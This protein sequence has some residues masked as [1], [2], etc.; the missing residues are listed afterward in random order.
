MRFL[1][2]TLCTLISISL[3]AQK[4]SPKK[5]VKVAEEFMA[6]GKFSDAGEAYGAAY[7]VKKDKEKWAYDAGYAHFRARNYSKA[8]KYFRPISK[9]NAQWPLAGFFYAKSLKA[10]GSFEKAAR[11]FRKF[12][13]NWQGDPNHDLLGMVE[14][15][16]LGCEQALTM[17]GA[18]MN[19]E[20]T[21]LDFN[22]ESEEFAPTPFSDDIIYFSTDSEG[23]VQIQRS[24]FTNGSWS[25]PIEAN[26]PQGPTGHTCQGVFNPDQTAFYFT[27][28][29]DDRPWESRDAVCEIYGTMKQNG[30][31]TSP[32]KLR[33]YIKMDGQTATQPCVAHADGMEYLYF[34]ADREGGQGGMDIWFCNREIG[35]ETFDFSFPENAGPVVNTA[36]DEFSPF[37]DSEEKT[38]YFSSNGHP[39]LGGF[40]IF[41]STGSG[42]KWMK[43][44][45]MPMP[46]NSSL[47]DYYYKKAPGSD[48]AFFASN[49]PTIAWERTTDDNVFQVGV[50]TNVLAQIS[51]DLFDQSSSK[52][53][54]N[55]TLM[56]HQVD[57][58]GQSSLL[59]TEHVVD[60]TF[61]IPVRVGFNYMLEVV[62][63][64]YAAQSREVKSDE[65]MQ[66]T[67][68]T[69]DFQLSPSSVADVVTTME[70]KNDIDAY[71]SGALA[72][73]K[74]EEINEWNEEEVDT[75]VEKTKETISMPDVVSTESVV[76]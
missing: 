27:V 3:S 54:E 30:S 31:W 19:M 37:F 11:S 38:L 67:V 12:K 36:G 53:V 41:S 34:T 10:I 52:L 8:L 72:D 56:M 22:T 71:T 46:V 32:E 6:E 60:G 26:L 25:V 58:M 4:V 55:A 69:A 14:N 48:V 29:M 23:T 73:T 9:D 45:Q 16:I 1:V 62:A 21:P 2:F 76:S 49:R 64:G 40:D 75:W 35:S 33:D 51:G 44:Q 24:Q 57:E 39:N 68:V 65:L 42:M 28:C 17:E 15:E 70:P 74:L 50:V 7:D 13:N 5:L 66:G 63:E 20:I 18:A 47:D 59:T 43:P 61:E